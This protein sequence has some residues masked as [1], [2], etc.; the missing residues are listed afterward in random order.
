M[1]REARTPWTRKIGK[2]SMTEEQNPL[3]Q[4]GAEIV[5]RVA[6][7]TALLVTVG[8]AVALIVHAVA[9]PARSWWILPASVL[10]GGALGLLNFRWL[11]IAVERVYL[12][13]GATPTGA[14][15]AGAFLNV[16]KLSVIFIVLFVVIKWQMLH[17]FA[18]LI[19]LSLCFL[20]ILWEGVTVMNRVKG[21][22][23]Q[24]TEDKGRKTDA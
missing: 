11:A 19:G 22:S 5:T 12:R 4:T 16:L 7:K 15:I 8:A 6:K 1:Q 18:L 20:A 14:N 21:E 17:V 9:R 10:F 23:A 24:E 2:E 3:R 13:K